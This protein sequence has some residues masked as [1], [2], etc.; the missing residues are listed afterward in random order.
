MLRLIFPFLLGCAP[1]LAS[2]QD[3]LLAPV[4]AEFEAALAAA[5]ARQPLPEPSEALRAYPLFPYVEAA[6]LRAALAL[7][8]SPEEAALDA[9]T[10]AFIQ[11]H[12]G[13]PVAR[14]LRRDW[15][16]A[17]AA[18][19]D[20]PRF[21][22]ALPAEGLEPDLLCHRISAWRATGGFEGLHEEALKLWMTGAQLPGACTEPFQ[23]LREEGWLTPERL[24]QR[25]RLALTAGT[26]DLAELLIR[27]LGDSARATPL[28]QWL[29]LQANP[30]AE[31]TTLAQSPGAEV[32]SGALLDAW[33]RV[34][35]RTPEDAM[36]LLPA[37]VVGRDEPTTAALTRLLALGLSWNRHPD[38]LRYFIAQTG[39]VEDREHEWRIR[40]ALWN[41]EWPLA[42]AWL[43][44]LPPTLASQARWRYWQ[45]RALEREGL[46]AQATPIYEA[47]AGGNNVFAALAAQRLGRGALPVNKPAPALNPELQAR[48]AIEPGFV[49]AYELFQIGRKAWAQSEWQAALNLLDRD[50]QM[51]A[52]HLA[53]GWGR[54][55]QGIS[56]AARVAVFDDF[57]LFYPRPHLQLV[58]LAAQTAGIPAP[59]I[60][61]VMRQES[62]F[63]ERAQS[64]ADALGLMQLLL[65]TAQSVARRWQWPLPSREDLFIPAINIPLGAA[66]L[67]EMTDRFGGQFLLTLAAYNAGPNA[68]ARWLPAQPMEADIW[69]E[70]IP[71]NE[72]RD[73]VHRILWNVAVFGWLAQGEPQDLS[74][75]LR[76]VAAPE[77]PTPTP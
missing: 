72:T 9:A 19:A 48:L 77:A 4:R 21:L 1:L 20:W 43:A 31:L 37:L 44:A 24:E 63:D 64:K 22:A 29:R 73:Y 41:G 34:T 47:L 3:S 38:A 18:R 5:E 13:Q 15:L 2:A 67:R 74:T 65:P 57:R 40:A 76:P 75:L 49:R 51:Q 42:Q 39:P 53:F 27:Q 28:R 32:E 7:R 17:L 6:R 46:L 14:G 69:I 16:L 36:P 70:N 68:A 52:A 10:E 58:G 25:A 54:F 45:A 55:V 66:Y 62:L 23:W 60:Y 56:A 30:L 26:R 71:F 12:A 35:R 61:S 59:W 8:P 33:A 11:T 50:A